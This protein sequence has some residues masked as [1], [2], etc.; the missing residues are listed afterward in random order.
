MS[1][2]RYL[3]G[4]ETRET[5][6][7]GPLGAILLLGP[8]RSDGRFSLLEHPLAPRAL[9]ALV[10]THRNEDEYSLVLEG[11]IGVE[12]GGEMFEAGPG[13]IVAK[14]RG[15]PHAFW[16]ATDE[17]ARILELIVP[18]GFG[19]Y[20][21]E[22]AEVFAH[23]GPPDL[24]ALAAVALRYELEVDPDSVGRL[25]EAHGLDLGVGRS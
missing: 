5:L 12:V 17:P 7:D 15:V 6:L 3:H 11:T 21:V 18:G 24:G 1:S 10:H 25:A 9:G 14:P 23:P 20:F 8:E 19:R 4:P 22:L 16:N 2:S 13:S